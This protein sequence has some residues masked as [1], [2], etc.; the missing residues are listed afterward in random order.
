MYRWTQMDTVSPRFSSERLDLVWS[1]V[2]VSTMHSNKCAMWSVRILALSFALSFHNLDYP[3]CSLEV[4]WVCLHEKEREG[5]RRKEDKAEIMSVRVRVV[6][7]VWVHLMFGCAGKGALREE[8]KIYL[9]CWQ[10]SIFQIQQQGKKQHARISACHK[11]QHH[12]PSMENKN[13]TAS[14]NSSGTVSDD[15]RK[16]ERMTMTRS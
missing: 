11:N 6:V 2:I 3:E 4:C 15:I 12:P 5:K 14:G 13:N 7:S 8:K 1:C 9:T 16:S 10:S